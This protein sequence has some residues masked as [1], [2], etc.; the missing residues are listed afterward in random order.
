MSWSTAAAARLSLGAT[1]PEGG[2]VAEAGIKPGLLLGVLTS[3]Y[4][5]AK[6]WR[7]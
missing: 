5:V 7:G 1:N 3:L 6:S 4:P 2:H